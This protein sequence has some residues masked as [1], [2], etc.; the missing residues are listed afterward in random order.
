MSKTWIA[1]AIKKKGSLRKSLGIKKGEKIPAA[2]LDRA[3]KAAG[4]LGRRARLA[5]T[6]RKMRK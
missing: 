2:T 3:A 6:L 5:K 4:K 1:S